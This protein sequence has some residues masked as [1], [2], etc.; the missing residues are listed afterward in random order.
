MAAALLTQRLKMRQL[1][2]HARR[3]GRRRYVLMPFPSG[4]GTF[5]FI[6]KQYCHFTFYIFSRS[7]RNC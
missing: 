7:I 6:K 1:Y 2:T 5:L 4:N 3:P